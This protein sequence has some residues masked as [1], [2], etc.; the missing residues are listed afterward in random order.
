MLY[1]V[2]KREDGRDVC[3]N[4]DGTATADKNQCELMPFGMAKRTAELYGGTVLSDV[5][6]FPKDFDETEESLD[7]TKES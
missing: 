6:A 2:V 3:V 4:T 1:L 5:E 7:E